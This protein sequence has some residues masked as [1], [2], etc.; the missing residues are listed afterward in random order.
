MAETVADIVKVIFTSEGVDHVSRA[1]EGVAARMG[2]FE[3]QASQTTAQGVRDRVRSAT[4]ERKEREG[5][6]AQMFKDID[7][8]EKASA[9]SADKASRD[10][11][12]SEKDAARERLR[13]EENLAKSKQRIL[14]NSARYAGQ[15]AERQAAAEIRSAERAA[16]ERTR[17]AERAARDIERRNKGWAGSAVGSVGGATSRVLGGVGMLAAG[18]LALGGGAGFADSIRDELGAERAAYA[19]SN[20]AYIKGASGA[21]GKR[22][23]PADLLAKAKGVQGVTNISKAEI[24]AGM[25]SYVAKTGSAELLAANDPMVMDA[26]KLAKAES[27]NFADVMSAAGLLRAQNPDLNP[28]AASAMLRNVVKQGQMGAV[29]MSDLASNAGK[30]TASSAAYASDQATTQRKLLGLTQVVYPVAGSVEESATSLT[31]LSADVLKH[32]DKFA[33]LDLKDKK[34]GRLKDA[35]EI[36]TKVLGATGGD[37]GKILNMGVGDRSIKI[38]EAVAKGY[39]TD[40]AAATG[41]DEQRKASAMASTRARIGQFTDATMSAGEV[42]E[43]FEHTMSQRAEKIDATMNRLKEILADK[44]LPIFERFMNR[45]EENMP[46]IERNIGKL[47]DLLAWFAANPFEGLGALV[48]GLVAK[49]IAGA[50]IGAA[51]KAAITSALQGG[52][53]VAANPRAL[54]P[55]G[56]GVSGGGGSISA[57]AGAGI[58]GLTVAGALDAAQS[59]DRG[60][61]ARSRGQQAAIGTAAQLGNIQ[62]ALR[63]GQVS[64]QQA[65]EALARANALVE[66]GNSTTAGDVANASF[67]GGGFIDAAGAA[68]GLG[69][70]VT[71][72][73]ESQEKIGEAAG[74]RDGQ[75]ALTDAIKALTKQMESQGT[76]ASA[77]GSLANAAHPARSG[78]P[79]D[80]H[81]K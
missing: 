81:G 36:I 48:A 51:A 53:A 54:L 8:K 65:K 79:V 72:T 13:E 63:A 64:P 41:T 22:F 66:K 39:Q 42:N 34:T 7:A 44:G 23:S 46:A 60:T 70:S 11:A 14:D 74:I 29:E 16:R 17:I 43:R 4:Q 57:A 68:L 33:G 26:A 31:H 37:I 5:V 52:G 55:S 59:I 24:L 38:F 25:Q 71:G 58:V 32:Y 6:Y 9:K 80:S 3:K 21:S 40:L 20:S 69:Q 73:K 78:P 62:R 15:V 12:K 45:L 47:A 28:E 56:I 27:A 77:G 49:D 67:A 35:D 76:V 61:D 2:R 1:F 50:A 19:L 75:K 18:A 10:K 30:I